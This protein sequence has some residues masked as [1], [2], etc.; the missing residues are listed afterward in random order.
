MSIVDDATIIGRHDPQ[1]HPHQGAKDGG[2][3]PD[4]DRD[5]TAV[6]HPAQHIAAH[7]VR[8][9]QILAAGRLQHILRMHLGIAVWGNDIGQRGDHEDQQAMLMPKTAV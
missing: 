4:I 6:D 8:A 9:K 7:L 5:A 3:H 2:D 1:R